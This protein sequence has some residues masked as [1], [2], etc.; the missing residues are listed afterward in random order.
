MLRVHRA[1]A[2]GPELSSMSPDRRTNKRRKRL[3][4]QRVHERVN[5]KKAAKVVQWEYCWLA[6]WCGEVWCADP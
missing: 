6:G 1:K 3:W 4:K 2:E 5:N